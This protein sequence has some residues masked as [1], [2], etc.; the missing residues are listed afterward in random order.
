MLPI[1]PPRPNYSVFA[2]TQ[3][4]LYLTPPPA[5]PISNFNVFPE[6]YPAPQASQPKSQ[7]QGAHAQRLSA[8]RYQV[9]AA[10]LTTFKP[11][12]SREVLI[13]APECIYNQINRSASSAGPLQMR[14]AD[15]K[16]LIEGVGF[17]WQQTNS[18]IFI[19]NESTDQAD[20]LAQPVGGSPPDDSKELSSRST[21]SPAN[22]ITPVRPGWVI[23]GKTCG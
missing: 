2:S 16:F 3:A 18:S 8:E 7:V 13:Q 15:G 11:D 23:T 22:L 17:L 5:K 9:T 4:A 20:L 19:S 10:R 6:Y 14:T 1:A 21:F 12:G